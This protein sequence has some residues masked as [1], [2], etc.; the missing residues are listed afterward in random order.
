M[1]YF[2]QDGSMHGWN[3]RK[4]YHPGAP[5]TR[6]L[7]DECAKKEVEI[8]TC[9]FADGKKHSHQKHPWKWAPFFGTTCDVCG[10]KC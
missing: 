1:A 8:E 7:C 2:A 10:L 3:D 9:V 6:V 5:I 4:G